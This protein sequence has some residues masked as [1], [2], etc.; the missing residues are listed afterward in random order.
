MALE[1]EKPA[2]GSTARQTKLLLVALMV[3][4]FNTGL[5][6]AVSYIGLGRVF[7]ANMTGNVVL[8]AF[9]A[10]GVSGLSVTR[11]L[12]SLGG[13]L[14]G[15]TIG[16]KLGTS[17]AAGNRRRL[18]LSAG[19]FEALLIFAAAVSAIGFEM[20]SSAPAHQLYTMIVLTALSMGLRNATVRQLGVADVTTTVLTL[21]LTGLAA[22]SPVAGGSN[23][24]PVRR[25]FSIIALFVG[26]LSGAYLLRYGVA[27]PLFVAGACVLFTTAA[28]T[29][30]AAT[31]VKE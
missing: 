13:F 24:R 19:I 6:D 18:I 5:I 11:A 15:A 2:P 23:P 20:R 29:V 27:L 12:S 16:G 21:T 14:I 28:Y 17:L 10:A 22:D 26:A 1:Q 7:V 31:V 9:A 25:I 3:L 30:I 8:L 4:T